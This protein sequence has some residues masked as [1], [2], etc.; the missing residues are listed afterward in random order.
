MDCAFCFRNRDRKD[1]DLSSA[2][3]VIDKLYSMGVKKLTFAGGEPLL[4]DFLPELLKKTQQYKMQASIT[5]NGILLEEQ[6]YKIVPYCDWI[7]FSLDATTSELQALQGRDALHFE[8]VLRLIE[9]ISKTAVKI[10]INTLITKKNCGN[11]IELAALIKTLPI[12]RWKVIRFYPVRGS[13]KIN[14]LLFNI[15]DEEFLNIE[16]SLK[17]YFFNTTV[18]L[19]VVNHDELEKEYFSIYCDGT[20]RFSSNN[21][22]H[23]SFNIITLEN[24]E[25]DWS[26]ERFDAKQHI[27][28]RRWLIE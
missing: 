25:L 26:D 8:R 4:I 2:F 3:K 21:N 27:T 12:K 16:K 9:K 7:T 24:E 19:D 23:E 28:K 14:A 6:W 5:T 17:S 15:S 1:L 13:A 10:K 18:K 11:I 20:V 22:D